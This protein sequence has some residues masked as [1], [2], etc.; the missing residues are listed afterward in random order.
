MTPEQC[1][2]E[3]F[4]F[5]S[6]RPGQREIIQSI[7]EHNNTL[8]VMPTGGGKSL[9]YQ[10][11]ALMLNGTAIIISPLIALMKDQHDALMDLNF[12]ATYINSSLS[13]E[14]SSERLRSVIN[15]DYKLVYIAPERLANEYFLRIL[16]QLNVSFLAVD[17]AH[18]ISEWG[19][20]FRPAY[21]NI[22]K[23]L[24][25]VNIP[26]VVALTATA[27]PEVQ[28]DIIT[29]LGME[30]TAVFVK[31]FDRA[32]LI[33]NTENI[34]KVAQKNERILEIINKTK[35]GST[36]I[37]CGSRSKTEQTFALLRDN[38]IKATYYHAGLNPAQRKQNQD[39][40]INDYVKVIVATTAF[41]MGIDKPDVR[42]II[43]INI[44]G[45]IEQYYQEAG[46]GG[47]D[48]NPSNCYLLYD[49]SDIKLQEFFIET[50]HP[51][52]ADFERVYNYLYKQDSR[53]L[54]VTAK[55]IAADLLMKEGTLQTILKR[56]RSLK[57]LDK[58]LSAT[59]GKIK[60]LYTRNALSTILKDLPSNTS[61][62]LDALIRTY[63]DEIVEQYMLLDKT[64]VIFKHQLNPN[65]FDEALA[66]LVMR[67]LIELQ[68]EIPTNA[69]ILLKEKMNFDELGINFTFQERHRL[70]AL[71]KLHQMMEYAQTAQCKRNYILDYFAD[72]SYVG[73][74]G[75][76]SACIERK[77][78]INKE[79]IEIQ[80][81][82]S[83]AAELNGRFGR[84]TLAKY[85]LGDKKD[86]NVEK[87]SLTKGKYFA[88]LN[89]L[90]IGVIYK[91]IDKCIGQGLLNRTSG[92]YPMI[93]ITHDGV[94]VCQE[95]VKPII[96]QRY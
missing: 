85:L 28:Q 17:E 1:L 9:C 80:F 44:P 5:N 69:I 21:L 15:G 34:S 6:F 18:C 38:G 45:S 75:K 13:M 96:Q 53:V 66:D 42:N 20:D 10:L 2:N 7:I 51:T 8:V 57:I 74:C 26:N 50:A 58:A 12:P 83:A 71:K 76:C 56:F 30:N 91:V 92:K 14:E 29:A 41:G 82:L 23:A 43:H 32:N 65:S 46:R 93:E 16:E 78:P 79:D 61:Q 90:K 3:Y 11:P 19:H 62:V 95:K 4:H 81:V 59:S 47:R 37:Y 63:T 60:F 87:Y 70:Y 35:T 22:A 64:K 54:T 86:S 36:I 39:L 49:Y 77:K 67:S 24:Q 88:K 55:D 40:F 48:G 84:V 31:G 27:T 33:Y 68:D 94:L 73:G 72:K 25:S 52:K 89:S